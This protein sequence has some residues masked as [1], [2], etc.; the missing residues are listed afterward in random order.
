MTPSR[1]SP[2]GCLPLQGPPYLPS[3]SRLISHSHPDSDRC[4][5]GPR[6]RVTLDPAEARY[7][8]ACKVTQANTYLGPCPESE[9]GKNSAQGQ[10]LER[11]VGKGRC[12]GCGVNVR[13]CVG[14]LRELAF[15]NGSR[16]GRRRSAGTDDATRASCNPPA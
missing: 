6:N 7:R 4:Q 13:I 11:E 12:A 14:K 16:G 10:G 1:P 15:G 8:I 3:S 5:P 2:R 9:A